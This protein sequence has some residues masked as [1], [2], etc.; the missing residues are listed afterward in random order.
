MIVAQFNYKV[1]KIIQ[2]IQNSF[3]NYLQFNTLFGTIPF[4]DDLCE[5]I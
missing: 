5:K 4:C 3:T 2:F 1:Q